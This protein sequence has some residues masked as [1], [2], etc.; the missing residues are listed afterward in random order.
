MSAEFD[1]AVA[2]SGLL[3]PGMLVVGGDLPA[4]I[5]DMVIAQME[6]ERLDKASRPM[7]SPWMPPIR[8]SRLP[9]AGI[10]TGAALLPF[11]EFLLPNPQP[12]REASSAQVAAA[13]ASG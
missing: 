3:A 11:L 10:T 13:S 9:A 8:S 4:D 5:V 12:A 6:R 7:A 1:A 2:I